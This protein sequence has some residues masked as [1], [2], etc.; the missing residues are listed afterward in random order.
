[1]HNLMRYSAMSEK[2][3]PIS[4]IEDPLIEAIWEIRF[5]SSLGSIEDI[6]PGLIFKELASEIKNSEGLPAK[7]IPIEIINSD[8]NLRYQPT[9]KLEAADYKILVGNRVLAFSFSVE[10]PGWAIFEKKILQIINILKNTNMINNIERFSLKYIDVIDKKIAGVNE[11][12]LSIKVG[13]HDINHHPFQLKSEIRDGD[14]VSIVQ[15]ISPVKAFAKNKHI[16]GVL[17]DIDTVQ[18][19]DNIFWEKHS[20]ML[21]NAHNHGKSIFFGLLSENVLEKLGAK[22]A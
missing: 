22:Y 7:K 14:V 17:I 4:L 5:S 15:I 9:V 3:I 16:D 6:L 8:P 20:E 11:L 21:S 12:F 13:D 18:T 1:M 10:Y 19:V 2:K